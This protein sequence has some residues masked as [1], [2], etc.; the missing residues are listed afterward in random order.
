M[1]II[2]M[3]WAHL[4]WW[5]VDRRIIYIYFGFGSPID[6]QISYTSIP[7][8][9]HLLANYYPV[10]VFF[11]LTGISLILSIENKRSLGINDL[12]IRK[13][14]IKRTIII[15]IIS[16][17]VFNLLIKGPVGLFY[18]SF[19]MLHLIALGGLITYF[20]L[21]FSKK[22]RLIIAIII[23]ILSPFIQVLF[24]YEEIHYLYPVQG[25]ILSNL[26]YSG[27]FPIFPWLFFVIIGSMI[28]EF[29]NEA[30][31]NGNI[32][33]FL[34]KIS[35]LGIIF[36]ILGATLPIF[37]YP[38]FT[39]FE[40]YPCTIPY[41]VF[42]TGTVLI[43]LSITNYLFDYKKEKFGFSRA[44]ILFGNFSLTIFIGHYYVGYRLTKIL[45]IYEK[46]SYSSAG[47]LTLSFYL[48]C[49]VFIIIWANYNNSKIS[50]EW[51]MKKISYRHFKE[52]GKE[53]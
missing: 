47:I 30:S 50:L 26:I 49:W 3:I 11:I 46:F 37:N 38:P 45:G 10:P 27:E 36:I 44:F 28:G 18:H 2:L 23:L 5:L 17:F 24:N 29:M 6:I 19:D 35:I 53:E 15:L 39:S 43:T 31:K 40:K 1:A 34:K 48:V 8:F 42:F 52:K 22:I 20:L 13:Y 7:L 51:I 4:M 32:I 25:G 9:L 33:P 14:V 21:K 41:I 16:Y 12:K